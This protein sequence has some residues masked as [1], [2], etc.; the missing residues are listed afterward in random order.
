M[1]ERR[2]IQEQRRG[3]RPRRSKERRRH[4]NER[5]AVV[6][7]ASTDLR[8]VTLERTP[9]EQPDCVRSAS[10]QWRIEA[11]SLNSGAGLAELTKALKEISE[12]LDLS[13]TKVQFVLG[14]EF[15]VTR[16]MR[17]SSEEV[18]SELQQL[19]QRSRLYLM[20]GTGEKITVSNLRQIDA[21][22]QS[23]VAAVCNKKTLD[24]IQQAALDAGLQIESIEPALVSTS[25]LVGRLKDAPSEPCLLIHIEK[26]TAE[27]GVCHEGRL[28][29]D[30][31]PGGHTDSK[32]L[33][34]IVQTHLNRLQRH[35]ARQLQGPPPTLRR[36][37]LCGEKSA[38]DSAM[39]LFSACEQFEVER[40][41]P[42]NIQATWEFEGNA[43]DSAMVPA[44]GSLLST[45]L[46]SS[47]RD[48]PD[49]MEHILASTRTPLRP[50]LVRSALPLVAILLIALTLLFENHHQ[51]SALDGLQRQVD[52]LALAQGRARELRLKFSSLDSKLAQ[53]K[54]LATGMQALPTA[55]TVT[56][57]GHCMPSDVW[58][59]RLTIEDMQ[60]VRLSGASYLEAGVF[61]FVRWLELAPA[62]EDVALRGTKAGQ[63]ASGPVIN[64]DV[65]LNLSDLLHDSKSPESVSFPSRRRPPSRF[66]ERLINASVEEVAHNE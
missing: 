16:A 34:E 55:S 20:L 9:E 31:R 4:G 22:H 6:E 47:E 43:T 54:V 2:N 11:P 36:L 59:S 29:L 63:S 57:L 1:S 19:E 27:V 14:G 37:Y 32:D 15:C 3:Q 42:E 23:A 49:F 48:A 17:G 8:I 25:R 56:R 53:F 7:V 10:L 35:V 24:T 33:V 64:F 65:E 60:S 50:I 58:L 12:R 21:R 13:G 38:V 51:Q 40:I 66:Q 62:F 18:R 41:A 30:Y 61:D 28:L 46:P 39:P 45:Y 26:G 52:A 44:L 5:F